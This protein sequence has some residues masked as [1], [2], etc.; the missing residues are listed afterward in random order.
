MRWAGW[1]PPDSYA[2][3]PGLSY[4]FFRQRYNRLL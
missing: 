1:M 3:W 4:R 2:A